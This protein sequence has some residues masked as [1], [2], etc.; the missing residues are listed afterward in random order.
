MLYGTESLAPDTPLT[1][2]LVSSVCTLVAEGASTRAACAASG[3]LL[4]TFYYHLE[5]DPE[6]SGVAYQAARVARAHTLSDHSF[7]LADE[8]RA[9]SGRATRH[10]ATGDTRA[11]ATAPLPRGALSELAT[12]IRLERELLGELEARDA[13]RHYGAAVAVTRQEV[14]VRVSFDPPERITPSARDSESLVEQ[15]DW[16]LLSDGKA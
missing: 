15:A 12:A 2:P 8:L 14:S 3:V 16:E 11:R 6:G 13:P 5:R 7:D 10:Q 1:S 9:A 4:R